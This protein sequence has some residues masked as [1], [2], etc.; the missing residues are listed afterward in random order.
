M[1]ILSALQYW[2]LMVFIQ[3]APLNELETGSKHTY[4]L[5]GEANWE[6]RFSIDEVVIDEDDMHWIISAGFNRHV[7]STA[8]H[9]VR[10]DVKDNGLY[11][12]EL[13]GGQGSML[14]PGETIHIKHKLPD[15][16]L[17]STDSTYVLERI[18][19]TEET[20][21]LTPQKTGKPDGFHCKKDVYQL[22]DMKIFVF[23]DEMFGLLSCRIKDEMTEINSVIKRKK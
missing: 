20:I 4:S 23:H 21:Q 17:V 2:Y 3:F 1:D 10:L 14:S 8:T 15:G 22:N 7:P 9:T 5:S 19:H 6:I 12:S 18:S 13:R 16:I 11:I